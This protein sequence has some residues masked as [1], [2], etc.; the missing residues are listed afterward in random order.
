MEKYFTEKQIYTS[1]FFGGPI[2][3]GILIYK[4]FKRIGED[5][6]ASLTL[7]LTFLFTVLLFYGLMQLPEQITDKLPNFLFT[8]LY[9]GIVYLIYH[10]Y[11]ADQINI[12]LIE[13]ENKASNWNV[14]ALTIMGFLINMIIIFIFAFSEPIFP[15]DKIELG[16]LKHEIF[17]DKGDIVESDLQNIGKVLTDFEYF[18]NE[19]RQSVRVEKS[20]DK[21]VLN[22]PIQQ[23]F[24]EDVDLLSELGYLKVY[25]SLETGKDFK[26]KLIHFDLSGKTLYKE[27]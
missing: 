22:I 14:T 1:T 10:R 27:L 25:L 26:L 5:K 24:W 7:L 21:Y 13:P 3:A 20:N 11:L 12:K 4:N 9:T 8:S 2:P 19:V 15:G 17:F 23:E 16:E 18:N 6:R